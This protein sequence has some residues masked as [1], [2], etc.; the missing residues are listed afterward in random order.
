[1][2]MFKALSDITTAPGITGNECSAADVIEGYFK[3]STPS[4]F[5]DVAGNLYARIGSGKPTVLVMAHMDEVGMMVT[6]IEDNGMLRLRSVAG[7]DPRVLPGSEVLVFGRQTLPG[8]IGA[9]P[10]HLLGEDKNEAY[11]IDE[12]CCDVGLPVNKVRELVAV[13]DFI[14]FAPFAPVKLQNG[15]IAGKTFDDR[16][17]VVSMME[18]MDILSH[19]KLNCTAI[20]CASV[21]EEKGGLGAFTGTYNANPDIAIA[22]D[23]C[24]APT[25]G[26]DE[27]R[28]APMDKVIFTRGSNLHPGVVDMLSATAKEQ[29]I[30]HD[31][32]VAMG[33]TGTDAWEIQ[34][35]RGGVATGLASLPIRY[36]HTSVECMDMETLKN[37]A[38]VLAGF[39]M[40]IGA[41][42]EEKLC[43]ND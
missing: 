10:P 3:A 30:P 17:L 37:C 14:T 15:R 18:A 38:K 36:M 13:G 6:M 2:D 5:R 27:F 25:P 8:V 20:F 9:I 21:Q 42:W 29:N 24:H 12:L 40:G 31:F 7:V 16:A 32:D 22:V 23:V 28:T 26:T 35:G 33:H 19:Y 43:W 4:V 41:D 34:I 39:I 11:K 1:M